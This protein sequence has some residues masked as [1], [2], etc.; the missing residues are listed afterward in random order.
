MVFFCGQL[1]FLA[2]VVFWV[3]GP[4]CRVFDLASHLRIFVKRCGL[5][6][7][8][9]ANGTKPRRL[10]ARYWLSGSRWRW[11]GAAAGGAGGGGGAQY[12]YPMLAVAARR[13]GAPV[14]HSR[15]A[16]RSLCCMGRTCRRGD[17]PRLVQTALADICACQRPMCLC[18]TDRARRHRVRPASRASP[19]CHARASAPCAYAVLAAAHVAPRAH[20]RH[21]A[22]AQVCVVRARV[23]RV[24]AACACALRAGAVRAGAVCLCRGLPT[25]SLSSR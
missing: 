14:S 22:V 2:L 9:G 12:A 4:N 1:F 15:K 23:M 21:D 8:V 13:P 10:D 3:G 5:A 20:A 18:S 24:C 6:I 16:S 7:W 11:G 25:Y 17:L 19:R